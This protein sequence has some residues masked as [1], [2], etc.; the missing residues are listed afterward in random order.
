MS[1]K[2][3][4]VTI[5][6][7]NEIDSNYRQ[8]AQEIVGTAKHFGCDQEELIEL[9]AEGMQ[10]V[11][12]IAHG[13]VLTRERGRPKEITDCDKVCYNNDKKEER[14]APTNGSVSPVC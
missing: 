1:N 2:N 14:Q 4:R 11:H 9:I 13:I 5:M 12:N 3:K 8:R 6:T 10:A 7:P